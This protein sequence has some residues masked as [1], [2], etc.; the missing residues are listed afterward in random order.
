MG[1]ASEAVTSTDP[2]P[3][4]EGIADVNGDGKLTID[5]N[6]ALLDRIAKKE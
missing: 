1:F 6:T 4:R 2:A 5:D 3:V